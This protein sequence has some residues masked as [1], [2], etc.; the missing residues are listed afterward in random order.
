MASRLQTLKCM[1][2]PLPVVNL[3]GST[4]TDWSLAAYDMT[5]KNDIINM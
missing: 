3:L 4:V 1:L 2:L 5:K